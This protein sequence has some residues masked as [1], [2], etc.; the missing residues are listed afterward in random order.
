MGMSLKRPEH[1]SSV[2]SENAWCLFHKDGSNCWWLSLAQA[3]GSVLSQGSFPLFPARDFSDCHLLPIH[4]DLAPS[5]K[6]IRRE[7]Q[8]ALLHHSL[9]SGWSFVIVTLHVGCFPASLF[10]SSLC[11]STSNS[12][13]KSKNSNRGAPSIPCTKY[14]WIPKA[15][16]SIQKTHN[17]RRCCC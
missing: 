3:I 9:L 2:P 7:P 10:S 5:A 4:L 12:I 13:L 16:V 6:T 8:I 15:E 17:Q 14:S 1:R 11:H